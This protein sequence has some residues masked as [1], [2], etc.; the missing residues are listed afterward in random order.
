[1]PETNFWVGLSENLHHNDDTNESGA[2]DWISGQARIVSG[3]I[4]LSN[5]GIS[6]SNEPGPTGM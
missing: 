5:M 4:E 6:T 2:H 1:M 3:D